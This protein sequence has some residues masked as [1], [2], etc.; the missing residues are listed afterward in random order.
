[1]TYEWERGERAV[2]GQMDS[3]SDTELVALSQQGDLE[4]FNR[5]IR[6]WDAG[7]YRFVRRTMGNAEDAQDIVQ[8]ALLKAF[9]NIGRLRDPAKFRAWL[10]HIALN[11]CRDWYRS[12]RA[13]ADARSYEE[14]TP[15][16]LRYVQAR[17]DAVATDARA[18]RSSTAD[19]LHRVLGQL[20]VEQRSAILLREYHGFTSEEIG[21]ITGVPAATVRTRIFYGLRT[22]RKILAEQ[23]I[24][25]ASLYRQ[26]DRT[27]RPI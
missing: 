21:Q 2:G 7:L 14:G 11:L 20:S 16:E 27:D 15:E 25:S 1:M 10:H 26:N 5:L 3:L 17:G 6:K 23:G 18:E 4:A 8:E 9:R 22:V 19:L 24:T 12:P 13:R